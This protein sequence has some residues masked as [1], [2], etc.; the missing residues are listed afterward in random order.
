MNNQLKRKII[1]LI[2]SFIF[3]ASWNWK[4]I[5]LLLA[6]TFIDFFASIQIH[7]SSSTK[8]KKLYLILSLSANLLILLIFKYYNFFLSS[9]DVVLPHMGLKTHFEIVSIII[10]L[11]VSFHTFQAMGYTIDV[12][13]NKIAPTRSIFDFALFI[14]FF[15]QLVAGPIIRAYDFFPHLQKYNFFNQIQLRKYLVIFLLGFFKKAVVADNVA[16]YIDAFYMSPQSYSTWSTWGALLL[17]LFQIYCDF[18]GYTDMA[19]ASAGLLGFDLPENFKFPYFSKSFSEFWQKWHISVT[20]WFRDY[21]YFPLGGGLSGNIKTVR[22]ILITFTLSGLWHG[23][24]WKFVIWGGFQGLGIILDK[25]LLNLLKPQLSRVITKTLNIFI[26]LFGFGW[27][28]LFTVFFRAPDTSS[29]LK[30]LQLCFQFNREGQCLTSYPFILFLIFVY[31]I[32]FINWKIPVKIWVEKVNE[33]IFYFLYGAIF[34]LSFALANINYRP[35][36]YFQF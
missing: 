35:F 2:A 16:K 20:N 5:P 1:L 22:N 26:F 17:Y 24:D 31:I 14:S 19:I 4:F 18:S 10:P 29:A 33:F 12:Y 9:F 25:I 3:Y 30:I 32:H 27:I 23:A 21:I 34:S 36:V 11:G 15:P 8:I 13:K 6:I 28:L 7:D